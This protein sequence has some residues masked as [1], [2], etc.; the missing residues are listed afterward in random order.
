MDAA[1]QKDGEGD[2]HSTTPSDPGRAEILA[3]GYC[4]SFP[5]CCISD[6]VYYSEKCHTLPHK[7]GN[8]FCCDFNVGVLQLVVLGWSMR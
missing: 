7:N 5:V 4:F 6:W 2:H 1:G 3:N 8:D